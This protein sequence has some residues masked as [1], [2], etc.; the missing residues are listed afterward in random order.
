[1]G[2]GVASQFHY[3]TNREGVGSDRAGSGAG[4]SAWRRGRTAKDLSY[5]S[6]ILEYMSTSPHSQ[7]I[8]PN[9]Y[10]YCEWCA[11]RFDPRSLSGRTPRYCKASHRVRASERRR[12]LLRPTEPPRRTHLPVPSLQSHPVGIE[13][14]AHDVIDFLAR[15]LGHETGNGRTVSPGTAG[16]WGFHRARPG[17]LPNK[18]GYVPSLCGT[19]IKIIG[20]PTGI[21][22]SQNSCRTCERL[23][24]LHPTH[25]AWWKASTQRTATALA[26]DL[27]STILAVGQATV[28]KRDPTETLK[29]VDQQLRNFVI[30]IGLPDPL[31]PSLHPKSTAA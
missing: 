19:M 18:R 25:D 8:H 3:G 11:T 31:E 28:E 2:L 29:R 15:P 14:R 12:G 16:R 10:L 5:P 30:Q 20:L 4:R 9:G 21:S 23:A 1:M 6:V 22:R 26:D 13:K 17:G 27:R 24:E 7:N